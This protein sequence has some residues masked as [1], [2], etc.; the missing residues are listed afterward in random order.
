MTPEENTLWQRLRGSKLG[1]RFRRQQIV[2]GFIVDF[3]CAA[4]SLIIE[5]DGPVHD[6]QR[7]KDRE[8]DLALAERGLYVLHITNEDVQNNI[9]AVLAQISEVA[10]SRHTDLDTA[11]AERAGDALPF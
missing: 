10:E 11:R 6:Y 1:V 5:V 7:A 8:R 3:Y 9:D 2:D 4:A